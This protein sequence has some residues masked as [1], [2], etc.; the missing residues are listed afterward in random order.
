MSAE[1]VVGLHWFLKEVRN[2]SEKNS[3]R[4]V[5]STKHAV[6]LAWRLRRDYIT[7]VLQ[8]PLSTRKR[9]SY[10]RLCVK[11]HCLRDPARCFSFYVPHFQ[12]NAVQKTFAFPVLLY[13]FT[14]TFILVITPTELE[15]CSQTVERLSFSF[16]TS[17]T[18]SIGMHETTREQLEKFH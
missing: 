2:G 16:S 14:P 17:V 4:R 6:I 8:T 11:P 15:V 7:L 9:V 18:S 10:Y 1:D 13:Q 3:L 12:T 5:V